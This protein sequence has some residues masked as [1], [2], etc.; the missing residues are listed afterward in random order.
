MDN[1]LTLFDLIGVLAR[2]RYREAEQ[3]FSTV[4]LNHTEARL[5]TLLQQQKGSA[6]QETLSG[7]IFVDRSNV[8][9]ALKSLE[10]AGYVERHKDATDKRANLVRLTAKGRKTVAEIS[11]LKRK[12]AQNFF[13]ALSEDEA[14]QIVDLLRKGLPHEDSE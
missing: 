7:L 4:G 11:R 12:M 3:H 2:R 5:L 14:G 8:G 9:R 13:G 10:N 1:L 6:T